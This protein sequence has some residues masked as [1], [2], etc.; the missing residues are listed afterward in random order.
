MVE[1]IQLTYPTE[2][3]DQLLSKIKQR[4]EG[5]ELDTISLKHDVGLMVLP[6]LA[7]F[8]Q[9]NYGKKTYKDLA[10]DIGWSVGE[11]Y[12]CVRFAQEY[13][14]LDDAL[15]NFSDVS[16]KLSWFNIQHLLYKPKERPKPEQ[17]ELLQEPF[18]F[19]IWNL[20]DK[21]PEGYGNA[22]FPGN[23]SPVILA[24]CLIRYTQP[25][26]T[27]LDPMAGSGTTY[28]VCKRYQRIPI[29]SDIQK[30]R[31]DL[32]NYQVNDAENLKLELPVDFI[33][34]HLPYLD[35]YKYTTDPCDLSNLNRN[36]FEAKLEKIFACLYQN[37]KRDKYF[38]VLIGD[39]RSSG[40]ID[41]T[42]I[43][44]QIGQKFFK[45]WDKIVT[46]TATATATHY[47]YQGNIGLSLNRAERY[48]YHLPIYDTLLIFRKE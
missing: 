17:T 27:V 32:P 38:A 23:T 39:V 48:N 16:E 36:E 20:P 10:K 30:W 47:A 6:H 18:K 25:G 13:P 42:S 2:W 46:A 11:I 4:M 31:Q 44:S 37:L 8:K 26:D 15:K 14:I 28:D 12:H 40:L 29:I 1:T 35:M 19:N 24:Q 22:E 7:K 3:Y 43:V 5:F 33:F 9:A 34:V 41:L 45:L 21:R